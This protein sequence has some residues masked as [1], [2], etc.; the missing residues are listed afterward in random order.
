M[1]ITSS[2]V[3]LN[4]DDVAASSAFLVEHFGF[5]EEMAAD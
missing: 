3:A 2:A 4:V 5:R 1:Q